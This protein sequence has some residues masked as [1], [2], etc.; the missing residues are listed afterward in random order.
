MR[1]KY[2]GAHP[3]QKVT[4]RVEIRRL[5]SLSGGLWAGRLWNDSAREAEI[6]V[7]R[8]RTPA[9]ASRR[10]S[11]RSEF[12]KYRNLAPKR[13]PLVLFCPRSRKPSIKGRISGSPAAGASRFRYVRPRRA[14]GRRCQSQRDGCAGGAPTGSERQRSIKAVSPDPRQPGPPDFDMST[15]D[16]YTST[17]FKLSPIGGR[18]RPPPRR[19]GFLRSGRRNSGAGWRAGVKFTYAEGNRGRKRLR[20]FQH[21]P[22]TGRARTGPRRAPGFRAA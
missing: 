14:R 22:W 5:T 1:G 13:R 19:S 9:E 18:E 4:S 3:G 11:T 6:R 8:P 7:C 15:R 12:G 20:E 2:P 16:V 17:D 21:D 10:V